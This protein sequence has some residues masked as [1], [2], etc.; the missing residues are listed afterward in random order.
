[1]TFNERGVDLLVDGSRIFFD[2]SNRTAEANG[3]KSIDCPTILEMLDRELK[4]TAQC[5]KGYSNPSVMAVRGYIHVT[6]RCNK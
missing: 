3:C 6:A 1:M 2:V 4:I 5:P